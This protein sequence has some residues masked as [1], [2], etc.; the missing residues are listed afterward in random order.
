MDVFL[1]ALQSVFDPLNLL[2]LFVA[3]LGG[4][5]IG[6]IPGL[7]VTMAIALAV[8]LTLWMDTTSSMMLLLGEKLKQ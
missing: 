6:A 3:T 4:I 7:T 8:P 5:T 2:L 1:T